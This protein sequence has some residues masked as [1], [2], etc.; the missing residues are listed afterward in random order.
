MKYEMVGFLKE[1]IAF[2]EELLAN[3]EDRLATREKTIQVMESIAES[4]QRQMLQWQNA[5]HNLKRSK[6]QLKIL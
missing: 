5:Y 3:R 2:L 6:R 4:R 1:R